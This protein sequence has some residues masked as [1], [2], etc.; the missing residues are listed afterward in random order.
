MTKPIT[1][2]ASAS[3]SDP[4]TTRIEATL[5][6]AAAE[7]PSLI[8]ANPI[9]EAQVADVDRRPADRVRDDVGGH[10]SHGRAPEIGIRKA[11]TTPEGG[12]NPHGRSSENKVAPPSSPDA[13]ID[14]NPVDPPTHPGGESTVKSAPA[15]SH[16]ANLLSATTGLDGRC[17]DGTTVRQ[18]PSLHQID[19]EEMERRIERGLRA[20][21]QK[22]RERARQDIANGL[23]IETASFLFKSEGFTA[24][25]VRSY[26]R[27]YVDEWVACDG[28]VD[29]ITAAVGYGATP[30]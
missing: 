25:D 10:S 3:P 13:S 18:A 15:L 21:G 2:I 26:Q 27:I 16:G 23:G 5:T 24:D 19:D 17:S 12:S 28:N 22:L 30:N 8:S 20:W 7:V 4:I 6:P 9:A 11:V 14:A 1:N 29:L